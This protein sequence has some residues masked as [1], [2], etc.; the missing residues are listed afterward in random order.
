MGC[1]LVWVDHAILG[2]TITKGHGL[3]FSVGFSCHFGSNHYKRAW[4]AHVI[5]GQTSSNSHGLLFS[6]CCSCYFGSNHYKWAL[7]TLYSGLLMPFWLKPVQKGGSL[8]WVTH[9]NLGQCYSNRN[10]LLFSVGWSYHFGSKHY[11]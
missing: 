7:V 1:S 9:V 10:G 6:V 3:L 8:V 4:V 5:L 2:Q 11:K